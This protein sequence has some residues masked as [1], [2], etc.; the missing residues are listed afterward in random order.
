M[1]LNTV[2]S[3]SAQTALLDIWK[4]NLFRDLEENSIMKSKRRK[5]NTYTVIKSLSLKPNTSKRTMTISSIDA[6]MLP[7]QLLVV[8]YKCLASQA[9]WWWSGENLAF[10]RFSYEIIKQA[11]A[12]RIARSEKNLFQSSESIEHENCL[13]LV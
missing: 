1:R 4:F 13:P 5:H 2:K 8:R 12:K 9:A 6:S 7:K 3:A 10:N 11:S